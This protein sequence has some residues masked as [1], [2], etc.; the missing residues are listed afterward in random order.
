VIDDDVGFTGAGRP[1]RGTGSS[2]TIA[3]FCSTYVGAL[4]FALS[5]LRR[6][7]LND[8]RNLAALT[9]FAALTRAREAERRDA[10]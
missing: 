2:T 10:I 7:L 1:Q 9:L 8:Q 4:S 5:G 3:K 6:A